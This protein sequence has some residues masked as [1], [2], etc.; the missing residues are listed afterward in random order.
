MSGFPR[1]GSGAVSSVFTRTG[2]VVAASNDYSVSQITGAAPLASPALT[3][4][5]TAPTPTAGNNTTLVA[6][7]AFVTGGIATAVSGLAPLASPAF[8]GTPTAP[9]ATVGTNT[10]QIA[11]TA[12]VLANAGGSALTHATGVLAS[13]VAGSG[14]VT[15]KIMDTSSLAAGTWLLTFMALVNPGAG[16]LVDLG[17]AMDTAVGTVSGVTNSLCGTTTNL[18]TTDFYEVTITTIV[19]ITTAGTVKLSGD[20]AV[21]YTVYAQSSVT[22]LP[23]TGYTAVKIG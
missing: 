13:N 20:S 22:S 19:T 6:T 11:T 8:T 9:T 15:T 1:G 21:S 23:A 14:G 18:G 3:G 16:A 2:A 12:F 10:T 7:T 5:P 4:T 17:I